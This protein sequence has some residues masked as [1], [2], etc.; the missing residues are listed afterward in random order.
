MPVYRLQEPIQEPYT[1]AA[2]RS[3]KPMLESPAVPASDANK[4]V[5]PTTI[6]IT[7]IMDMD[8]AMLRPKRTRPRQ[9]DRSRTIRLPGPPDGIGHLRIRCSL[10]RKLSD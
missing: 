10:S 5:H 2:F 8:M 4:V 7:T 1:P 9:K 3:W 6:I